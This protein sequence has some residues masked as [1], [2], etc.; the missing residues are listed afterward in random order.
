MLDPALRVAVVE[1]GAALGGNHT[2]SFHAT[3]VTAENHQWIEPLIVHRWAGQ[4]IRFPAHRRRLG[5]G[6]RSITSERLAAVI[7]PALGPVA[8]FLKSEIAAL[9]PDRIQLADGRTISAGAVI[10]ARGQR[11]GS[12]FDLGYQKF[13]GQVLRFAK[14]HGLSAP[15][16]MDATIPQTDGYRFFYVLPFDEMTALVEDTY[17]ADT[18]RLFTGPLAAEIEAYCA[19]QGWTIARVL[20]EEEGILPIAL[21]GDIEKHLGPDDGIARAG[22]GAGLFHPLTGYSF[23]DAV[24]LAEKMARSGE[25]SGAGLSALARR[26]AVETWRER[27]F[28]RMLARFLFVAARPQNRYRVME[29]FYKLPQPLIERFYAGV[30][31]KRDKMRVLVGKPPVSFARAVACI[32]DTGWRRLQRYES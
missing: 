4:D 20:R 5:T 13:F 10:D 27:G 26:H 25:R 6:Y 29:R 32:D 23:P 2:W 21:A 11:D 12:A 3:D 18:T 17:Y 9:A 30:S 8:L 14:P 7:E 16:I 15:I 19:A 31:T 24:R 1:R 22:L 28:Y